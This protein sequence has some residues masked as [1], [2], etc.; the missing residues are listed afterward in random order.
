LETA[1]KGK[2][3]WAF[4]KLTFGEP[5]PASTMVGRVVLS[6]AIAVSAILGM[7]STVRLSGQKKLLISL[8]IIFMSLSFALAVETQP[9]QQMAVVYVLDERGNPISDALVTIS[10]P[11]TASDV[12]DGGYCIFRNIPA[13]TYSITASAEGYITRAKE[14]I[15]EAGQISYI[16]VFLSP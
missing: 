10:G 8:I 16:F 11:F 14:E 6:A 2:E 9:T 7:V 12:T 15:I 3:I 4:F 5:P 13:G 1:I